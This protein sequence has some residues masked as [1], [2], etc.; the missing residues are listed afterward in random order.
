LAGGP[1]ATVAPASK[2]DYEKLFGTAEPS[3]DGPAIRGDVLMS[4]SLLAGASSG[5]DRSQVFKPLLPAHELKVWYARHPSL[6]SVDPLG[7][8]LQAFAKTEA[9]DRIPYRPEELA[10]CGAVVVAVPAREPAFLPSDAGERFRKFAARQD[11]V[12]LC[13][14]DRSEN[15]RPAPGV[16]YADYPISLARLHAL[17]T[18]TA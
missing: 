6:S 4:A 11:L 18:A 17:L 3:I 10:G 16:V 13:L 1:E 8:A 14:T 12:V 15:V 7:A 9:R 5:G 2:T